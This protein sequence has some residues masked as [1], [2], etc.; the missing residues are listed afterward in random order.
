MEDWAYGASWSSGGV[1]CAPTTLA[2]KGMYPEKQT[3]YG[4][5]TH[6]AINLLVETAY[7]KTP[8]EGMLGTSKDVFHAG[9][10]ATGAEGDGH[11]TRNIRLCWM[12]TDAVEPYV[13]ITGGLLA[14]KAP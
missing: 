8:A 10:G 13:E 12:I 5:S 2:A 6:R 7:D 11:V 1:K 4:N 3:V 14:S 9:G